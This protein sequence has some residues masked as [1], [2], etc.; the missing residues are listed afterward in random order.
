MLPKAQ[1]YINPVGILKKFQTKEIKDKLAYTLISQ[2]IKYAKKKNYKEVETWHISN[3]PN[4]KEI[5][6]SIGFK[7]KYTL[8][9]F[10][11]EI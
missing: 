6:N 1:S 9:N 7:S 10:I 4:I 3:I 11:K 5:Y 8:I 2:A